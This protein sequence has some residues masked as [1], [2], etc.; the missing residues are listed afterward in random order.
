MDA[1]GAM[2][3]TGGTASTDFPLKAPYQSTFAGGFEDIFVTKFAADGQSLVFSTYFGGSG[4]D[5]A[6]VRCR[7]RHTSSFPGF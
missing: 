3:V 7:G 4:D 5:L 2:V 6:Y 1:S